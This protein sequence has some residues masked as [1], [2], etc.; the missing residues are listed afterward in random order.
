MGRACGAALAAWLA[1][2][3]SL[4]QAQEPTLLLGFVPRPGLAEV[5][6]GKPAGTYLPLAVAIVRKAGLA[7]ELEALPQ[8]RLLTEVSVNRP[9]Y[10]ALGIY[11][12]PERAA[13]GKYSQP[14]FRDPGLIVVATRSK[15]A[16]FARHRSFVE[17]SGDSRLKLGIIAG[18]SYGATLD[19]V[20]RA[21]RGNV[22]QFVGTYNQNFAKIVAGRVDYVLTFPAEFETVAG[23]FPEYGQRLMR[24][25]YP[26]MPLGVTRHFLCSKAVSDSLLERLNGAIGPQS[27]ANPP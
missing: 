17:L 20:L 4:A 22:E 18:Y 13:Y 9:N 2:A 8:K 12:T 27:G 3:A 5:I 26:D 14:F 24:F 23:R 15:Q 25:D 6:D 1:G 21:M 19:P 7:F 10:C 16:E 11:V